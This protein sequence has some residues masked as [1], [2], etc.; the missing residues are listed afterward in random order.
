[1]S[2]VILAACVFPY[3]QSVLWIEDMR[4]LHSELRNEFKVNLETQEQEFVENLGHESCVHE[5]AHE[6]QNPME[7]H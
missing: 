2:F 7:N 5:H 3:F 6:H 4:L 1:M